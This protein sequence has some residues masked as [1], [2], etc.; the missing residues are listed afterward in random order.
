MKKKN[1]KIFILLALTLILLTFKVSA[2][3]IYQSLED[4]ALSISDGSF[5]NDSVLVESAGDTASQ[6]LLPQN[7]L[8]YMT[9]NL[10]GIFSGSHPKM[11][12]VFAIIFISALVQIFSK[13]LGNAANIT[14]TVSLL[15]LILICLN[16]TAPLLI[17]V[18]DYLEKHISFMISVTSTSSVLLASSGNVSGA[19]ASS[20]SS[21]FI[22]AF[23]E[24]CAVYIILPA[25]KTIIVLSCAG[26]I[27]GFIDL[28]GIIN[29]LKSF[30]GYGI[31]L[32]F[33]VFLGVHALTVNI[34]AN[35]DSLAFRSIRFTFARL[36]PVAGGMMSESIKSVLAGM[37]IIKSAAGG[38]GIAYIIYTAI[39]AVISVLLAKIVILAGIQL[40]KI[41][42]VRRHLSFLEGLNGAYNLLFAIC[43]F[44][45]FGGIIILAVF[46]N[47]RLSI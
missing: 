37:N 42:G 46:I 44:A 38:I 39:P 36:I 43:V 32:I 31:G 24:V 12:G 5:E 26:A 3:Q 35:T 2:E 9:D 18:T 17:T 41:F 27:S 11:L 4:A 20:A 33:S 14:D 13:N 16:I 25:V 7:I 22:T 8:K 45:A 30:C 29:F 28:S 47:T 10:K 15:S 34:A 23:T 40:S 21:A 19:A 1:N 6:A